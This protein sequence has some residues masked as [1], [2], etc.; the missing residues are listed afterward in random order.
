[1]S[2]DPAL[3]TAETAA[4]TGGG[5][6]AGLL[7]ARFDGASEGPLGE[8]ARAYARRV[9]VGPLDEPGIDALA[10]QVA[11]LFEF[12]SERRAGDIHVRAF[13]PDGARDG[14]SC[15]GSVLEAN[16]DDMPFLID[17][18]TEELRRR[19][20]AVRNVMH[21]VI[22]VERDG[23]GRLAAVVPALTRTLGPR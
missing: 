13:N 8:F 14:W 7:L 15:R 2:S 1:V 3:P 10:A 20:L 22:G 18:V 23:N 19:G 6:L 11:G 9:A 5:N 4:G 12:I 16:V 17:S 21:P